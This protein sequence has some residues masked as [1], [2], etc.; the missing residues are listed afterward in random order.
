M[1]T[2]QLS[3]RPYAMAMLV[4]LLMAC[5][6]TGSG[7]QNGR[8]LSDPA[9]N[10]DGVLRVL[11]F[12]DMEGLAGQDDWRQALWFPPYADEYAQGRKWLTA[13]MNA[14]VAGLYAGGADEV[15]V[16]DAHG[17]ANPNPDLLV[18]EL[19]PRV[20]FVFRDEPFHPYYGL[21]ESG[22]Y[23][24][25]AAVAMHAK[26]GTEGFMAHTVEIGAEMI[27]NDMSV[28]ETEIIGYLWGTIGVPFILVAGD[29]K[30]GQ[31]LETMPWIEYVTTKIATSAST[32][33]LRPIDEVHAEL[34]DRAQRALEN[35]SQ[36][37]AMTLTTPVRMALRAVPPSSIEM[38]A[39]VPGVAYDND[40]ITFESAT[41]REGFDGWGAL[42][43]ISTTGWN[44]RWFGIMGSQ[45]NAL[46][47]MGEFL[48][49]VMTTWLDFE[50]GRWTPPPPEKPPAGHQYHGPR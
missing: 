17:S 50:S 13:E 10:A 46:E 22:T 47:I 40:Q 30:L 6:G 9:S 14:V 44:D 1:R 12:Y 18:D 8:I 7:E 3:A 29:D 33:D 49:S 4:C 42:V 32:A 41:F 45:P 31:D 24:A 23:D 5:G 28:T 34:Q 2:L 25:L 26:T 43:A 21:M 19:D 35:L 36:A 37:R 27:V 38:F 20:E 16:V 11:V 15:H 48:G 39:G